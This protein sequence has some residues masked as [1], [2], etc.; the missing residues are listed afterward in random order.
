VLVTGAHGFVGPHVVRRLRDSRGVPADRISV[1]RSADR[2]LRIFEN[3]RHVLEDQDVVL[4]LAADAGGLGYSTHHSAQ[5]YYNC[6]L[7]DLHVIEAARQA[8]VARLICVSSSTA[9]PE[10]APSPLEE[11]TLFDGLPRESHLGYGLAKRNL[12]TLAS[13]YHRQYGMQIA[14]IISSNAYGPGDESDPAS[15]HVVPATIL[16]CL[17][18]PELTVW[19][20]GSAIRDFFYVEDLAEAILLAAESL[21]P[22]EY[23]NVGSGR[24]V[25]IRELVSAIARSTGFAGP[26]RYDTSKPGGEARRIVSIE[27]A[28]RL[29]GFEPA[30]SLEEGLRL[31]VEW[32]RRAERPGA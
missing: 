16:K 26:I 8:A 29:I 27:K 21:P 4:H 25:S 9:Y 3:A 28:R 11:H 18:D 13:V 5:Q 31:T 14:A 6:S 7:I 17:R 20:D 2:D 30:F 22:A 32:Y 15:S 1:P 19:G 10:R 12:I 24:P 23:V